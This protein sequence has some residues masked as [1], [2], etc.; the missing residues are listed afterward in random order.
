MEDVMRPG[1]EGL[2]QQFSSSQTIAWKTGTSFGFRDGWAIGVTPKNVV[3]V[4][5]GNT[6]GEGRPGLIGVHTAAPILFDIFRLLPTVPFFQKPV[7]NY[8]YIPVCRQTGYR[9]NID[10]PDVDT[11][12]MPPNGEKVPLCMYHKM[13]NLDA[14]GSFRV[15]EQC[16]SPTNMLHKSWF[17]LSPAME[18]YY[19]QRNADYKILPPFKTGCDF[20]ETGKSIELIYPQEGAKIYV[21]LEISG[22]KGKT[23]FTAAHRKTG[24]KIF[25]SLDDNFVGTTQS[26][27]QLA[28][29]PSVG[30]HI[31]TL[32]DENGVSISRQF[33]ILEKERH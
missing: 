14:A 23:V 32:V 27:H 31:I 20:A 16:E 17:I 24:A 30:K 26:F 5:V 22:E 7:Y 2:W 18:Y 15:T 21:P 12:F 33:E 13:I 11:L 8:A 9:A 10:C 4:W 25:W 28:L 1:E 19:K 3:A 6:D 29:D